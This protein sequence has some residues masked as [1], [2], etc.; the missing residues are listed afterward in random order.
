MKFKQFK[1]ILELHQETNK[2]FDALYDL[3]FD[4]LENEKFPVWANSDKMFSHLMESH[5]TDAGLDWINWFIYDNEFGTNGLTADD[6]GIPIC[7][8]LK[9]LFKYIK[10]YKK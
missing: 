6:N 1:K 9:S 2:M 5:Y 4:F 3:G 7:S 10:Q 8:D